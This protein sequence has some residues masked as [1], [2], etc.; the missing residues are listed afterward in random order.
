MSESTNQPIIID[1]SNIREERQK[2]NNNN[3][4]EII[5]S[6]N[7]IELKNQCNIKELDRILKDYNIS[8]EELVEKCNKEDLLAKMT[9]RQI[10]KC[11]SRQGSSDEAVQ[12]QTC[13]KT[14]SKYKININQLPNDALRPHK[15]GKIISK[16]QFKLIPDKNS[17]L[18]SFDAE[19]TGILQGYVF[20]KVVYGNG[21]H[22]DN[23]FEE[24]HTFADW[25]HKFGDPELL[26]V[27]L[28]DTDLTTKFEQ[29]K[30]KAVEQKNLLVANHIEFQKYIIDDYSL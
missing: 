29:L 23:V 8:L 24:A 1:F 9:S 15:D 13:H 17:C 19:I 11:A 25:V 7:L 14:S 30:L 5:K 26:Y 16:E 4:Y 2:I 20:A 21:G 6:K 12:I 10:S 3:I 28:I 22:Q 27:L 18:K